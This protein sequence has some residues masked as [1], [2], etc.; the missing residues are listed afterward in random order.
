MAD[1]VADTITSLP[2]DDVMVRAV[3]FFST[4]R[5]RATSQSSRSVTFEG[6]GP[7]PWFL[8][9]L[10]FLGFLFFIL[11][12]IIMYLMLIRR[13]RRFT[14]LVV[15]ATAQDGKTQVVISHPKFARS[16]VQRFCD[17]LPK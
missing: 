2:P 9:L 3:Q 8:V 7:V 10:T 17:G 14:N 5:W 4:E 6:K 11:P 16:L 15:T 1:L 13:V 12:G